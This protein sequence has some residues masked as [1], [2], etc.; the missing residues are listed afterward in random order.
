MSAA[1]SKEKLE[2]LESAVDRI[3]EARHIG[4]EI[5]DRNPPSKEI[6]RTMGLAE[7]DP[8]KS[9]KLYYGNIQKALRKFLPPRQRTSLVAR[10]LVAV[11]L[12]HKEK[13]GIKSGKRGADSRMAKTDDMV[14]L[15][16]VLSEWSETPEDIMKLIYI[17]LEKNKSLGY[18]PEER[19]LFDYL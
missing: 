3:V 17:L 18:V 12:T 16:D 19:S 9:Y 11:L 2:Q 15:I 13:E 7:Q 10:E 5:F 8:E 6:I 14:N 1:L 4:D